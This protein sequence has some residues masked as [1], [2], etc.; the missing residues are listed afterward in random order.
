MRPLS[1]GTAAPSFWPT[2]SQ[3]TLDGDRF[4]EWKSSWSGKFQSF[5]PPI[6]S[7]G[8]HEIPAGLANFVRS[9]G[10]LARVLVFTN[11]KGGYAIQQF[12]PGRQHPE[13]SFRFSFFQDSKSGM[14]CIGSAT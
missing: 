10:N 13:F 2:S 5:D 11:D 12:F 7:I 14:N 1:R 9:A 3:A 4:K 8:T 6:R